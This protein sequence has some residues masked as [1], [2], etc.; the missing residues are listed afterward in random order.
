MGS[1]RDVAPCSV[2]ADRRLIA[3]PFPSLPGLVTTE[4][5]QYLSGC[6]AVAHSTAEPSAV[7]LPLRTIIIASISPR[8]SALA[9]HLAR[10]AAACRLHCD[11]LECTHAASLLTIPGPRDPPLRQRCSACDD[12]ACCTGCGACYDD[13]VCRRAPSSAKLSVAIPSL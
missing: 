9:V 11:A 4:V 13:L 7:L 2:C 8:V 5:P 6:A 10:A 12:C 1:A 3:G